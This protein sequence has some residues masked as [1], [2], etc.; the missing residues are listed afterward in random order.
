MSYDDIESLKKREQ[1]IDETYDDL[2][3]YEHKMTELVGDYHSIQTEEHYVLE[4]VVYYSQ[5]TVSE[6]HAVQ[7]LE[8]KEAIERHRYSEFDTIEETI[9]Q[10]KKKCRQVLD[11]TREKRYLLEQL[12]AEQEEDDCAKN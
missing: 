8:I 9:N 12:E 2:E 7:Q 4:E 3:R 1:L 6:S 5:G 10:Q 11:E